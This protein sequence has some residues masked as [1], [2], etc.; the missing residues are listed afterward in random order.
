MPRFIKL[1]VI[2]LLL[3]AL[4][5]TGFAQF[6]RLSFFI[7]AG[8]GSGIGGVIYLNPNISV[9]ETFSPYVVAGGGLS[10]STTFR[11][12]LSSFS[13]LIGLNYFY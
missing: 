6:R 10:P 1:I 5:T 2:Q 9:S 7:N 11:V 4:A 8:H 3:M 12:N 13:V